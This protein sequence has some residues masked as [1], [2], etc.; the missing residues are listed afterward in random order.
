LTKLIL[1]MVLAGV[2]SLVAVD[3]VFNLRGNLTFVA[4]RNSKR[5]LQVKLSSG[6]WKAVAEVG[7]AD[8]FGSLKDQARTP[9]ATWKTLEVRRPAEGIWQYLTQAV[10]GA[11]IHVVEFD[12]AQYEFATSFRDKFE[13]TTARERLHAEDAMFAITANFRD[14]EGKPLGLV[15]RAGQQVNRPFPAWTGYFFV[16]D[17]KPWFGPKSLFE[18]TPGVLTEASQGY[19]S[20]LKNHTVFSY[21]DLAPNKYFDGNRL[22]YR[23]LAGVRQDGRVVFILSGNGGLLNIGEAAELARKMNVKHATLLDG[24]K[25]LQYSMGFV[26]WPHHFHAFNTW[27]DIKKE[28][29]QRERSPV[30]IVAKRKAGA[31][32][33]T[34]EGKLR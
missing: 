18:E 12:P 30:F 25:A 10:I 23:A 24:G 4:F 34:S 13:L 16:K 21:V 3:Y 7:T 14:P 20:L 2:L 8:L 19:P 33:A 29:L 17:G 26:G 6:E 22:S 31:R 28:P 27:L 1:L 9:G 32:L 15:V 5:P 11:E